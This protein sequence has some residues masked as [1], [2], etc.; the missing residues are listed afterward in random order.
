MQEKRV[1][2]NTVST[3]SCVLITVVYTDS[4]NTHARTRTLLRDERRKQTACISSFK[5]FSSV[6]FLSWCDPW[7]FW[8][9]EH[10]LNGWK[11][12]YVAVKEGAQAL[13]A[14]GFSANTQTLYSR[15]FCCWWNLHEAKISNMKFPPAPLRPPCRCSNVRG[16][17]RL[18][19]LAA[20]KRCCRH[21]CSYALWELKFHC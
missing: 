2:T 13:E 15:G 8:H 6:F 5:H 12:C 18:R 11:L 17:I 16:L 21:L 9:W 1:V 7:D 20:V 19:R 3:K 4:L 14:L 10:I